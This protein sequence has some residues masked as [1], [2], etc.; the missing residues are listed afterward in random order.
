MKRRS[1]DLL[2][3]LAVFLVLSLMI[4]GFAQGVVRHTDGTHITA[5]Q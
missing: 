4:T 1:P 3:I 5:N 2:V